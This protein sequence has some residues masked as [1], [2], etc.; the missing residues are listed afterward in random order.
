MGAPDVVNKS[1]FYGISSTSNM[2]Q[3]TE[4]VL[5]DTVA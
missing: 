1:F 2:V 4:Q 3:W 5:F